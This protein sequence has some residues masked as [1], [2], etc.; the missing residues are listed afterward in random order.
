MEKAVQA[1][2]E[3]KSR[4]SQ[5]FESFVDQF[6]FSFKQLRQSSKQL[7]KAMNYIA[8]IRTSTLNQGSQKTSYIN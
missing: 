2:I 6:K 4:G 1:R 7:N 8:L 3:S 5:L